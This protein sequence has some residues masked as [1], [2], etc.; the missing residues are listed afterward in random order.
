[1]TARSQ[2]AATI[3]N[4]EIFAIGGGAISRGDFVERYNAS[5]DKW[6]GCVSLNCNRCFPAI[7]M[8]RD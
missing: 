4:G 1:M 7:T 6:V 2:L 8:I 5:E 3:Y